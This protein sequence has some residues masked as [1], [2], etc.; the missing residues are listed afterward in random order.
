MTEGISWGAI[1]DRLGGS[2]AFEPLPAGDYDV[3][4][5]ESSAVRA[6]TGKPMIK[7]RFEV[8][9]GPRAGRKFFHNFVI[10]TQGENAE[11]A[12]AVFFRNMK[13]FGLDE[14]YFRSD[15]PLD[16]VAKAVLGKVCKVTTTVREWQGQLN[17]NV[18]RIQAATPGVALAAATPVSSNGSGAPVPTGL[19]P[20]APVQAPPA[21]A[22]VP[23]PQPEQY[24]VPA[25]PAP[26]PPVVTTPPT[27]PPPPPLPV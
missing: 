25:H 23:A 2:Q 27:L 11:K 15:P 6:S 10:T 26:A 21:P 14:A 7:V 1:L 18:T 17:E 4:I 3:R 9:S 5:A 20:V 24:N 12:M 22:Y 16:Q 8:T 19:P 13:V